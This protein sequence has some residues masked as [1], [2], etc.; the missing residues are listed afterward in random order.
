LDLK[1]VTSALPWLKVEAC[2]IISEILVDMCL[3]SVTGVS[4]LKILTVGVT[5]S[6]LFSKIGIEAA[7]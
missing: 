5:L 7:F 4:A 3:I 1:I 2:S 6:I